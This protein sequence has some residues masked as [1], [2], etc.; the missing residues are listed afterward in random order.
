MGKGKKK[1]L[2]QYKELVAAHMQ[3]RPSAASS[4][5]RVVKWS[6]QRRGEGKQ[7][8]QTAHSRLGYMQQ[9]MY[10]ISRGARNFVR[11][12]GGRS[13]GRGQWG[14]GSHHQGRNYYQGQ[15]YDTQSR[16]SASLVTGPDT[17]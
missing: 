11:G 16:T 17:K 7:R 2:E 8:L 10:S 3:S 4:Q 12:G 15:Q 14:R 9:D 1:A 6:E 5:G 13:Y